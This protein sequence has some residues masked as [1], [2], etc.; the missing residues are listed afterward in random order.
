MKNFIFLKWFVRYLDPI[1]VLIERIGLKFCLDFGTDLK[2]SR[3]NASLVFKALLLFTLMHSNFI[4]SQ[5]NF[6]NGQAASLVIGQASFTANVASC[7]QNGLYAPSYTAISSKG[8]LAVSEQSGGRVK[9]WNSIPTANGANASVVVGKTGFTACSYTGV[10]ASSIN[11]SNGVAFSPDGTKLIVTDFGNNRVLIWN[12]IPTVNGQ[13][14]DVVLGQP[15]FTSNNVGVSATA[16]NGPTGVF[17]SSDGRLLVA[18]RGNHRILIWN[19]IPTSTNAP[20]DVVVGQTVFSSPGG[21]SSATTMLNPWGVCV[22]PNGKLLVA[23]SANNRVL[24]WNTVP[25]AN[26][27][28]ADV[29]IGQSIMVTSG[30]GT[31][32]TSFNA[33][34]G[35]TVSPSGILAI[36]EFGN[37]RVVVYNSIPTVNGAAADVVLGQPNFTSLTSFYPSGSPTNNNMMSVYNASFDLNGRLFVVGRDMNRVLVFGTAP[38]TPVNLGVGI[39]STLSTACLGASTTVTVTLTNATATA[40]SGV[41][42]TASLPAGFAYSSH[43]ASGGTYNPASGYWTVGAVPAS[44]TRTLTIN[45]VA[46]ASGNL[47]A[48]ASIVQS[49]QLDSDLTDNGASLAY[50][51]AG[52]VPAPTGA[53]NQ[54][55]CNVASVS[56]LVVS[57]TTIKWYATASGGLPLSGSLSLVSGTTYYASQTLG[58]CEGTTRLPVTVTL[59]PLVTFYADTDGDGFGNALSSANFCVIQPGYVLNSTDCNDSQLQYQDLDG[60]GFGSTTLVACGVANAIDTNDALLTYVDA[61]ADGFGSTIL[62]PSGVTNTLDCN[63]SQLNYTDLD[64]DGFGVFP[65]V[66]CGVVT[67]A[68]DT[69]DNLLTYVDGDGDGFGST[70]FAPSGVTNTLDC[71]DAQLQYQDLDGD[72]FGSSVLVACGLTNNLDCDD[73]QVRYLDA[74]ADGYGSL[75]SIKVA[76]GG[77]LFSTDCDDANAAIHPGA[78]DVC[79]DGIDNDCN[80]VIDN[81]GLPG[82]CVPVVTS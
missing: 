64:G 32:T 41:I 10:S 23:D 79:R 1:N 70:T 7:S 16:M 74:D 26:G 62:A 72:G 80:G 25:T 13:N 61:D 75:A 45:G 40:A 15:N 4:F 60:D 12:T 71:N 53:V 54:T 73:N 36:G 68:I 39:T 38:T 19:S 76:C 46:N 63:D 27:A 65:L 67:N 22:A 59:Q 28:A 52:V 44:G 37:S 48:Y 49:N 30:A 58:I 18:D 78:V 5:I 3:G 17:V 42:A 29:V 77:S 66:P 2:P 9:L 21:G 31:S 34:I 43:A 50:T 51:I 24:V 56:N 69:N 47:S 8:V 55:F 81:V 11:N 57:G 33:P 35:V 82:G 14:A 20:A 6:T